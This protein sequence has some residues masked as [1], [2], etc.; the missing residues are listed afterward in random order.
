MAAAGSDGQAGRRGGVGG[1][2]AVAGGVVALGRRRRRASAPAA[3]VARG[4]V[5]GGHDTGGDLGG[6][7][8]VVLDDEQLT[9]RTRAPARASRG[10]VRMRGSTLPTARRPSGRGAARVV[11]NGRGRPTRPARLG[12]AARRPPGAQGAGRRHG[13]H[14]P[15]RPPAQPGQDAGPGAARPARSTPARSWSSAS[16]P[17]PWIPSWRR[18]RGTSPPTAWS[19]AS[20][21][22]DGRRVAVCA[23]DFT[24]MAGSMGDVGRA[25]DGPP[26]RAGAAPAHPAGVA[27]R[28]GRRP[29]PV[30][31]GLDLRRHGRPVPRAGGPERRRAPGGGH[32]R[33]LR[34]R[35]RLHPRRWPTSCRW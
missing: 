29:H 9:T 34:R 12:T 8:V 6:A 24:V 17:T 7:A 15:R 22:I 35:D 5:A 2:R 26:P 20:A 4:G 30:D 13:R 1:R 18:P 14:R 23:Y 25:E 28:L 31:Q 27:A 11:S 16:W 33:P 19:R 21:T 3:A 10:A 32:A